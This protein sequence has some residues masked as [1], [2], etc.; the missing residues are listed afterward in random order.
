MKS[1]LTCNRCH[2]SITITYADTSSVIV[3]GE[4]EIDVCC[5]IN[6][7]KLQCGYDEDTPNWEIER[8]MK[9]E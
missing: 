5:K 9:N 2:N 8:D 3:K 4:T 7:Y 1:Y 6:I